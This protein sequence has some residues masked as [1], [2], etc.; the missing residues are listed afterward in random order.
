MSPRVKRFLQKYS[1]VVGG[2][3]GERKKFATRLQELD[4][5]AANPKKV[6]AY[7]K[8]LGQARGEGQVLVRKGKMTQAELDEAMSM[9]KAPVAS[10]P[11]RAT[12]GKAGTK[13]RPSDESVPAEGA[14]EVPV[15]TAEAQ[16][17]EDTTSTEGGGGLLKVGLAAAAVGAAVLGAKAYFGV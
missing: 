6:D 16:Y 5:L 13:F 8:K 10:T 7:T 14:A 15:S 3:T 1:L 17:V 2:L 12:D 4:I 9:F 11:S